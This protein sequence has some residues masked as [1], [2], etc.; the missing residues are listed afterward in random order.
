L[1]SRTA[2]G[3]QLAN[4]YVSV[5]DCATYCTDRGLTFGA[6]PTT[7][8]EQAI[9]RASA[10]I[11]GLYRDRFPGFKRNGRSQGWNGRARMPTTIQ[12]N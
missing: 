11:D 5:D 1:L 12:T 6:S 9:I 2:P 4:A 3:Y 7:T 10:A 8:G